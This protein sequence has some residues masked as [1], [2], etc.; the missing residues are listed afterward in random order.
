MRELDYQRPPIPSSNIDSN[1]S[2]LRPL[3]FREVPPYRTTKQVRYH[4][5]P[6][7]TQT[8]LLRD[9]NQELIDFEVENMITEVTGQALAN[10]VKLLEFIS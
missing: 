5:L 6:P 3:D 2:L 4:D 7:D 10:K 9:I 1:L 8:R